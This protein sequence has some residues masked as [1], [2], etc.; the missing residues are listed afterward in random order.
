MST[1]IAKKIADRSGDPDLLKLLSE[2]LSGTEL[3]SLLLEVIRNRTKKLSAPALLKLYQLNQFVK[4]ADLDA[5]VLKE[6]EIELLKVF[7]YH[8]FEPIEL[9]PVCILGSCSVV[10][11][12][13]QNKVLSALRGTEVLA[14]ATNALA[15]HV[16]D[17]KKR[18]VWAP[19]SPSEK[20]RL[21]T[22]QRHVRTQSIASPGFTPH[23][24]I[25]C[26]VTSGLD[27]GSCTFEKEA[28]FEHLILIN[29]IFKTFYHVE[30]INIR[31]LCRSGYRDSFQLTKDVREYI[32]DRVPGINIDIV[33][34]P[35]KEITYYKGIQYKVDIKW[36]GRIFEIADGGFVDWTQQ[37]LQNKKERFL[38]SGFGFEFMLR[39][40]NNML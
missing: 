32:S 33:K 40:M 17:L 22:I 16:C 10:G 9:S 29:E 28:L 20:F 30:D 1:I 12:A 36:K 6:N 5:V 26:F 38:I 4:P 3:N 11:P 7:K 35:E 14:D 13:D 24:K 21:A 37:I 23:F 2:K 34:T 18:K 15:L 25:G 19:Q 39:I 8:S 31:L 27:T